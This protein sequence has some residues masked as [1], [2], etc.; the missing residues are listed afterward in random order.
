MK[1]IIILGTLIL[2]CYGAVKDSDLDGVPDNLDKCPN[3]SFLESVD[4]S[5]C[6]TTQLKKL[7]KSK[8]KFNLNMGYEYD[9]Y[10]S[11]HNSQLVFTSLSA[12]KKKIK[13]TLFVSMLNNNGEKYK[14]SDV[15]G[16]FYYYVD[17]NR[18][19]GFKM[20]AK[21]YF[22]TD[23]NQKTDYAFLAEASYYFKKFIFSLSEKHKIYGETA[24]R[25]K[26]TVTLEG[27]IYYK[28]LYISSYIYTENSAYD[29]KK[30]YKYAGAALFYQLNKK[31]SVGIDS[32]FD[33][34]ENKNYTIS[35]SIGYS[36]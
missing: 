27:D 28:K 31:I 21:A 17:F 4:I 29:S 35:S 11:Y 7:N 12:K 3:T 25:A 18:N 10:K 33:I 1:K 34:Q 22:P 15:I 23:Y 19:I 13:T 8:I 36:F 32:S 26:D 20:G 6:S 5:G 14:L 30:W 24:L 2:L 9:N 16:S